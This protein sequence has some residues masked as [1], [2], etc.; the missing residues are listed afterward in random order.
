MI[1]KIWEIHYSISKYFLDDQCRDAFKS[2]IM[3]TFSVKAANELEDS[4]M[5]MEIH[6]YKPETKI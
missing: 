4:K 6:F 2:N 1:V 3:K 5:E